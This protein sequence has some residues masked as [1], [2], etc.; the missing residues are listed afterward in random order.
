MKLATRIS[1]FFLT[2]LAIVLIGFS[3]SIYWLVQSHL[4]RQADERLAGSTRHPDGSCRIGTGRTRV[5]SKRSAL[6][7]R[8]KHH[9]RTTF[10]GSFR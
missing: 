2:A 1:I 3:A 5:G 6:G 10:V 8:S 7:S 9:E 4:Y